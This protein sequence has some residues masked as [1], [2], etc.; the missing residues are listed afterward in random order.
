MVRCL[1]EAI[2][3]HTRDENSGSAASNSTHDAT[4]DQV[5]DKNGM[6]QVTCVWLHG[7][8]V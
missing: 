2:R 8:P 6:D 5:I 3:A 1:R 4:E 7:W